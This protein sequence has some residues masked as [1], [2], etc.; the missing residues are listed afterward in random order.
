VNK[1][2]KQHFSIVYSLL[3]PALVLYKRTKRQSAENQEDFHREREREREREMSGAEKVV[4]VTGASGYIASWL[5]KLLLQRGYTVKASVRD[6]SQYS[7][8]SFLNFGIFSTNYTWVS[9]VADVSL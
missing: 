3:S 1:N 7:T 2:G 8:L 6:P 4:C 9:F 5:V